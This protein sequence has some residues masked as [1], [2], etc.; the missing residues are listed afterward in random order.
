SAHR[1][2]DLRHLRIGYAPYSESFTRPGDRRRFC[3]YAKKR[4]I[5]FE[6]ARGSEVYDVVVVTAAGDISFWSE[7]S[8]GKAIIVF[9]LI[10][11]YL[12]VPAFN[13]KS[14]LRGFAKYAAGQNKRLLW[15]YRR[16]IE[17]MC[18]RADAVICT[19]IEQREQIHPHCRNVHVILDFHDTI[20]RTSK[21]DYAAGDIFHLVWEGLPGNLDFLSEI[22]DVLLDLRKEH[23]I[24]LH[25]V[26]DLRYGKYL[27]GRFGQRRTEIDARK[28]FAPLYVHEWNEATCSAIICACD[29]ALIP[30][31]S[32]DPLCS[33]KPENKLL[34]FW[35]MGMPTVVSATPAYARAMQD[36]GLAMACQN[37]SDWR[38]TLERYI[39]SELSRREAGQ[40]GKTFAEQHYGEERMLAQWDSA[41]DSVLK[42]PGDLQNTF[43]PRH[44]N[45]GQNRPALQPVRPGLETTQE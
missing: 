18:Q 45:P 6:I 30:V 21:K 24:A 32:H 37:A 14:L 7:Y 12:A 40:K 3:S 20:V 43:P 9:D 29:L 36:C 25:A 16:G 44:G 11:S 27:G 33:G 28:I 31:P 39:S 13:P 2:N 42:T 5:P 34:L 23:P 35:R 26:T 17:R 38:E 19:T 22:Q 10:D 41:F 1:M 8:R 4:N 15:N